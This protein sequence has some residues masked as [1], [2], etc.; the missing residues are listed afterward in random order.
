MSDTTLIRG[1]TI[2]TAEREW[3]GD[4]LIA[5]EKV[6]AIG[7]NLQAP[8]GARH[9]PACAHGTA[10]HGHGERG[11][12][13]QRH[14]VRRG[15]RHDHDH[16]LLHSG[17]AAVDARGVPH[18]ARAREEGHR[19]LQLPHG[20]HVVGPAGVRRD[21]H[22]LPR[23]RR[24]Q[25]QALHGLQERDHGG[26]R[27]PDR[28]LRA[29]A[30]PGRH[31]HGARRERRPGVPHAVEGEAANR[32]CQIAG[33]VGVPLY[34]VHT[35]CR[36]AM[37]A[38]A[39]AKLAGHRVFGESLVQHLVIDDSVYRNTDWRSAAHHVMSPPFRAPEHQQALWGGLQGG[40]IEV[41]GTDHCTFRTEQKAMGKSDFRKIPNG[42]GGL[43]ERMSVL[44]HHGVRTGRITP[45]EFVAATSANAAR[46]F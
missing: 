32:A 36:Q 39:R 9:R 33:V 27:H 16:R 20:G 12:L 17:A 25:L 11:R 6:A 8:A 22:A 41:I 44:W 40:T 34:V 4:V 14:G 46:I 15:G 35:S 1:G 7:E 13:P 5:G 21:G 37:E 38:I 23:P 43:E 10:L 45:C 42:T 31:L 19:R 18:L 3:R 30:R 24:E 26:R 28:Q 2:V 29:R